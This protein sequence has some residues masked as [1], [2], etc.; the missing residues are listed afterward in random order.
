MP[1]PP[2]AFSIGTAKPMPTN[3]R[4]SVRVQDCG[5]DADHFAFVGHQGSAGTAGI[6]GRVELDQ[7][8]QQPLAFGR[9][10]LAAQA[11][12]HARGHRRA[13]AEREPDG[14]H[15]VAL[16]QVAGARAGSPGP[17]RRAV[18]APAARPGRSRAA[19]RPPPRP[20]RSRPRRPRR[21]ASPRT[22]RAGW[23]ESC[24][25]PGPR[26][27]CRRRAPC[28]CLPRRPRP[29][30][31]PARPRGHHLVGLGRRRGQ[32]LGLQ[33]LEH[34]RVDVVLGDLLRRRPGAIQRDPAP[35][36]PRRRAAGVA[37]HSGRQA[38][39]KG[40]V[41]RLLRAA[42][43]PSQAAMPRPARPRAAVA[44][45]RPR[46]RRASTGCTT[47]RASSAPPA[48]ETTSS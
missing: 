31:A 24:R 6:G 1:M 15:L 11:R 34:R 36:A 45:A 22:R 12:D 41:A 9:P 8:G 38:A 28:P 42:I 43:R 29:A 37:G 35:S 13:D 32:G 27:R 48:Q 46:P 19:P 39:A 33:R 14:H 47:P 26:R 16:A 3:T 10:E 44:A 2:A 30:P 5:D 20:T 25:F 40:S 23:S 17:G 4:C 18:S 21:C 7:V